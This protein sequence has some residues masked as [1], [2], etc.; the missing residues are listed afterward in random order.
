MASCAWVPPCCAF[1]WRLTGRQ[2]ASASLSRKQTLQGRSPALLARCQSSASSFCWEHARNRGTLVLQSGRPQ[3]TER[4]CNQGCSFPTNTFQQ[5]NNQ[6]TL[7]PQQYFLVRAWCSSQMLTASFQ[8]VR[9]V[10]VL[11]LMMKNLMPA[12]WSDSRTFAG[13][14]QPSRTRR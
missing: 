10:S 6:P 12:P 11:S 5:F 2:P 8:A 3:L 7:T 4:S 14:K 13:F 1:L 9:R